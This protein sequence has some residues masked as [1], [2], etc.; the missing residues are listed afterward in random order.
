M[1]HLPA[2]QIHDL[3]FHYGKKK[4][5]HTLSLSVQPGECVTLIGPSGAGKSTLFRILTGLL[6]CQSGQITFPARCASNQTQNV[7]HKKQPIAYMMQEDLL[8]PWRSVLDNITLAAELGPFP[9]SREKNIHLAH[10]LLCDIGLAD[11][12]NC[13]PHELSGGMRQ[14]VS[15]ARALLT[16]RDLLLLD[17]PFSSLDLYLREQ[18]HA[19]LQSI[20][21]QYGTTLLLITHDFRDAIHLSNRIILLQEGHFVQEWTIEDSVKE[22]ATRF[23]LLYNALRHAI[24]E[25]VHV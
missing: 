21:R 23:G 16:N 9:Q 6:P 20:Q 25:G 8:L 7:L 3:S 15:L 22:D 4:I 11:K 24:K 14:R 18:M 2:I 10:Q 13:L 17:E 19:L 1:T 5:L 12:E